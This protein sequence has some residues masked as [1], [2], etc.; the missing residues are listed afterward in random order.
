MLSR[1]LTMKP[2]IEQLEDRT[3]LSRLIVLASGL[4]LLDVVTEERGGIYIVRPDGTGLKQITAFQTH[5]FNFSGDG[6]ILSDD[7]PAFSPDGKQIVFTSNRD[8][9]NL[10]VPLFEQDFE[11]YVMD[12]NGTNVRRLTT[13][14]GIDTSRPSRPTAPRSP[15]PRPARAIWTSG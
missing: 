2:R 9:E 8:A 3:V 11:I 10:S 12:A 7:H 5:G 4:N 15:S 1:R 13:S 6:L 14:P